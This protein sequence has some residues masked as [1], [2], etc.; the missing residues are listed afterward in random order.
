MGSLQLAVLD[1]TCYKA[2]PSAS[3][4]LDS[5]LLEVKLKNLSWSY[6][7]IPPEYCCLFFVWA[8]ALPV[9]SLP[10]PAPDSPCTLEASNC[11]S[12]ELVNI[13]IC[14]SVC[15]ECAREEG[16]ACEWSA[17]TRGAGLCASGLECR[18]EECIVDQT[19]LPACCSQPGA[20][21]G[22]PG[23]CR[24]SK[25]S[26]GGVTN[27]ERRWHDWSEWGACSAACGLGSRTRRRSAVGEEG[28]EVEHG[29]C[30]GDCRDDNE[31]TNAV[32]PEADETF[33]PFFSRGMF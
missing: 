3:K 19:A 18:G 31:D 8:L 5:R 21:R 1:T 14:A 28:F 32:E 10:C 30:Q 17:E 24:R 26:S 11:L 22:V 25:R 27:V 7:N 29:D 15:Q 4:L 20:C 13:T 16:G 33:I 6:T 12:G 9:S 23:V 2:L